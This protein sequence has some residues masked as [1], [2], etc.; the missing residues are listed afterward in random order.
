ME[1]S[2]DWM[3]TF[4]GR[5]FWP[6]DPYPSE[7][8]I[9]DIAHSLAM[10]CRF[11]GHCLRFYSVAEHSV[12]VS[13]SLPTN[14]RLWG[15]LHD[16]AEAYVLDVVRP[17]KPYLPGYREI[18]ER[19]MVAICEHFGLDY[20]ANPLTMPSAVKLADNRILLTEREQNMLP[21]SHV[22]GL[23]Q[24]AAGAGMGPLEVTLQFWSPD[25]AE[26]QFLEEFAAISDLGISAIEAERAMK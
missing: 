7:I 21:T 25:E 2:G 3:Q 18:E 24:A 12:L 4:T 11:A 19:V 26:H 8:S 13:R 6:I 17:L 1:R 10:Q 5:Q 14:F 16:A 22:W 15:L 23:A 9:E 20:V